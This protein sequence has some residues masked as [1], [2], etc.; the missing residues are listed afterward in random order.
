[1]KSIVARA[2]AVEAPRGPNPTAPA[3]R[4]RGVVLVRTPATTAGINCII[5][6]GICSETELTPQARPPFQSSTSSHVRG[7][8]IFSSIS[9]TS[10]PIRMPL[11]YAS[12]SHLLP[13]SSR[14]RFARKSPP[15]P[16]K[17]TPIEPVNSLAPL[18]KA[19]PTSLCSGATS[20][21]VSPG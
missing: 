18:S 17:V 21:D 1:M 7:L 11:W 9:L 12:E 20:A 8:F 13:A 15:K 6:V 3:T 4:P 5:K 10:I 14:P 2:V 16:L 19:R